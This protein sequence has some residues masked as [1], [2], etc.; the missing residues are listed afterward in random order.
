MI[1]VWKRPSTWTV[2]KAK[3]L[4]SANRMIWVLSKDL[5]Q[6]QTGRWV[7]AWIALV[8]FVGLC[9]SLSYNLT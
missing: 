5:Y 3:S 1:G 8:L 4:G 2:E 7:W 9:V 6:T